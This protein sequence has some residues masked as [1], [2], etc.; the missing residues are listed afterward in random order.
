MLSKRIR[1]FLFLILL[2]PTFAFAELKINSLQEGAGASAALQD[3][4]T[5]HYTGWLEDGT[6]F[7][8]SHDRDAPFS[9][10]LGQGQVIPGW[11]QGIAG[12]RVGEIRELIIPPQL[13]YGAQGAG[14]VIPPNATLRFEVEM[15]AI[16]PPPF[17]NLDNATLQELMDAGI[18][19]IDV[20]RPDEWEQTGV[21]KGSYLLTA[22]DHR[23]HLVPDFLQDMQELVAQDEPF[24]LVC[25]VGNRTGVLSRALAEHAGYTEVHNLQDG[26]LD[27][28]A[29][30]LE[31]TTQCPAL[32][33]RNQ[34]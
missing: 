30:D 9:L 13:A 27:W 5:V 7:D 8:S 24:V 31:V 23:G 21:I 11:E 3:T 17:T 16:T 14:G 26:I 29:K 10:V 33:S 1:N 6:Q 2:W 28:I 15:L 4:V 20:R 25:R 32:A 22:F 12:M 18:K 19:V 34:C